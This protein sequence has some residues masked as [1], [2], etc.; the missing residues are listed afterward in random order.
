[1][2]APVEGLPVLVYEDAAVQIF[3]VKTTDPAWDRPGG[4]TRRATLDKPGSP[5]ANRAT[6]QAKAAAALAANTADVAADTAIQA[7][8][9]TLTATTGAL[10]VAQLSNAVRLLAQ[11]VSVLA[12]H[13]STAKLELNA[14]ARLVLGQLDTISDT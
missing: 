4:Y 14:L 5:G 9:A 13:D 3:E 8:A 2:T 1:M 10:T 11:G 7:Q 6:I 12:G